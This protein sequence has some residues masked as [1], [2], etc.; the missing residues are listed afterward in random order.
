MWS[1][2]RERRTRCRKTRG[3]VMDESWLALALVPGI[4]A[5]RFAELLDRFETPDGA[6]SAP[7]E[8]LCTV[9]KITAPVAEAIRQADRKAAA[10]ALHRLAERGDRKSTRLNSSHHVI[11]YAVFCWT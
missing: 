5:A 10:R 8:V 4:G 2:R 11:S 7:F 6:L 3:S 9:P 1:P